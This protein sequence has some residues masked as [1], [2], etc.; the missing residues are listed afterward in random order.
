MEWRLIPAGTSRSQMR[1][2]KDE[3]WV[4]LGIAFGCLSGRGRACMWIDGGG[5]AQVQFFHLLAGTLG[6]RPIASQWHSSNDGPPCRNSFRNHLMNLVEDLEHQCTR[7]GLHAVGSRRGSGRAGRQGKGG[8]GRGGC[9]SGRDS[10]GAD[11]GPQRPGKGLPPAG[12]GSADAPGDSRPGARRPPGGGRRAARRASR[13]ARSSGPS[14][15]RPAKA[16]KPSTTRAIAAARP[17][18]PRGGWE[19]A[20]QDRAAA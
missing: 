11:P 13:R 10:Q 2:T 9:T 8:A 15:A 3:A 4:L 7:G 14:R 16:R 19:R 5:G 12:A 20:S 6:S 1:T 17:G 18:Q